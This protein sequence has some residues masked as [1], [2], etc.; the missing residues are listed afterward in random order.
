VNEKRKSTPSTPPESLPT[1][2]LPEQAEKEVHVPYW[3]TPAPL[4]P[5]REIHPR[6]P[7]PP[8]PAGEEVPDD[9]PSPPVELD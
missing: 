5:G 3:D 6:Q 4:P 9:A 1:A 7:I 2:E 8:V